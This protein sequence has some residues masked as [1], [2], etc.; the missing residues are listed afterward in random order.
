M[1]EVTRTYEF[2]VFAIKLKTVKPEEMKI[3]KFC[4]FC[5]SISAVKQLLTYWTL[6][7]FHR[8]IYVRR[9]EYNNDFVWSAIRINQQT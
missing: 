3:M 4:T 8:T 2:W 1:K 5:Y 9:Y 7:K 6:T